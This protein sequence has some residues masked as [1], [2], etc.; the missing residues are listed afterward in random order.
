MLPPYFPEEN[1]PA[2]KRQVTTKRN[3]GQLR[4]DGWGELGGDGDL[5]YFGNPATM[6]ID[7]RP[8]ALRP[9]LSMGLPFR[10]WLSLFRVYATTVLYYSRAAVN[11]FGV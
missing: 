5:R 9:H 3:G 10:L 1:L 6:V 2:S 7:R 11:A 4:T 8:V